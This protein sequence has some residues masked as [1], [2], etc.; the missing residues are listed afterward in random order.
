MDLNIYFKQLAIEHQ[1]V[2]HTEEKKAFFREYAS[3]RILLDTDFHKN[4]R[5]CGNN[6]IISQFNDDG[7]LPVPANDFSR[8]E[9]IGTLYIFSRI[10][11]ANME[12]ARL[13]T[14]SLR[15][16]IYSRI[17]HDM[18]EQVI[19]RNFVINQMASTTIGRVAD[20]FYGI[21]INI[22]YSQ[23]FTAPYDA[24]KWDDIIS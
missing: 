22:S 9:M 4:L 20:N 23:K 24:A 15:N 10:I 18:S 2:L 13:V 17:K 21:A 3:A 7:P 14:K 12:A 8:E 11:D 1:S 5:A 19:E 16:D 6:V